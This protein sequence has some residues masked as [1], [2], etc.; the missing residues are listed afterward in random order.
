MDLRNRFGV[1]GSYFLGVAGIGFTLPFLPPF[2][3]AQGLTDSNIG[4]I[5][6]LGTL[7]GLAQY[8]FGILS[9]RWNCRKPFL[10]GILALLALATLLL[11]SAHGLLWLTLIVLLFAENGMCRATIESLAGAEVTF[12]SPR[13]QVGAA[14]GALRFW[15][16]VGI[17]LVALGGGLIAHYWNES[18]I[19]IPLAVLQG[20]AILFALLIHE[21]AAPAN[22]VLPGPCEDG[23]A[24]EPAAS[25]TRDWARD[26]ILWLFLAAAVAFHASAAPGGVYLSRFMQ[27]DLGAGKE[28]LSGAFI[29]GMITWMLVVRPAGRLADRI[30]RRPLLLLGWAAV[31]VRLLLLCVAQAPWQVLVIQ[32]LDGLSQ[33]MFSVLAATWV[34]DRLADARRAGQAQV[35]VGSALVVGSVLGLLLSTLLVDALG[36]RLLFAACASC[37]ALGLVLLL[38]FVPETLCPRPAVLGPRGSVV[39][40]AP[41]GSASNP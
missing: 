8:P 10:I 9:D 6:T 31:S 18:A 1:Y 11:S 14:L 4:L 7:A 21:D 3:A 13:D 38:L 27:V 35:L 25:S 12:L 29:V 15:K 24:A 41:A 22:P 37:G 20:A 17:I 2:L 40:S 19:L 26:P 33:G 28:W 30:G 34:T 5:S 36:Y 39:E 32:V 16:P 23:P